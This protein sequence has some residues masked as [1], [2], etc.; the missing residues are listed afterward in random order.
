MTA[1][2]RSHLTQPFYDL[3]Q[4]AKKEA[5]QDIEGLCQELNAISFQK[6]FHLREAPEK[7]KR[8]QDIFGQITEKSTQLA[9]KHPLLGL[10]L[11]TCEKQTPSTKSALDPLDLC[12]PHRSKSFVNFF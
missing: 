2:F 11:A 10:D 6:H 8:I 3:D 1:T 9:K 4:K 7:L 5:I 12:L